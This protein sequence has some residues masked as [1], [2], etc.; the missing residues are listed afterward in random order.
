MADSR[1]VPAGRMKIHL[2]DPARACSLL[3]AFDGSDCAASAEAGGT[4][5][6]VVPWV[7]SPEDIRQARVELL[8]FVRSWAAAQPGVSFR[9]G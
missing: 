4:V 5:E 8:F 9:V 1:N 2:D 6:V 7:R 3:A